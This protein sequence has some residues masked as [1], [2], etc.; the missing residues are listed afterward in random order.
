MKMFIKGKPIRYGY[1]LW[2]LAGE[3]GY[4]YCLIIYQGKSEGKS[5]VPLGT[6]V[7]N[8]LLE[9]VIR[10]SNPRDHFIFMDN[11]FTSYNLLS[12]LKQKNF[13]ATGTVRQNRSGGESEL[14]LSDK[15]LQNQGR[16]SYDFRTDGRI[17]VAKWQDNSTVL[18]ASNHFTHEPLQVSKQRVKQETV[19]VTQPFLI[20]KYNEGKNKIV[21]IS[22][23]YCLFYL[24]QYVLTMIIAFASLYIFFQVWEVWTYMTDC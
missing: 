23:T 12:D 10:L 14:M 18:V 2:I 13:K 5:T 6:K 7:M 11:F 21:F 8:M 17:F 9:P 1:K 22:L 20:R 19:N 24:L 15:D 3:D 16:G 4:P